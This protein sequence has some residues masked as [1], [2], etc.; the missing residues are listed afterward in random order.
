MDDQTEPANPDESGSVPEA[1]PNDHGL[2]ALQFDGEVDHPP[3][4]G[5]ASTDGIDETVD[6]DEV[7]V[8]AALSLDEAAS[9]LDPAPIPDED[10][11][12][13]EGTSFPT[14]EAPDQTEVEPLP[15]PEE[16]DPDHPNTETDDAGTVSAVTGD[17]QEAAE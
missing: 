9:M 15:A 1:D 6:E 13:E 11:T 3:H 10:G 4:I 7:A 12:S 17:D 16:D 14:S 8:A 5:V 2:G